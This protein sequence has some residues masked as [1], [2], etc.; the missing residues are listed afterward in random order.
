M[1]LNFNGADIRSVAKTI[2]GD[3]LEM[4]FVVDPRF[5]GN[6]ALSSTGPIR[7]KDVLP[8]LESALRMSDVAI[9]HQENLI[10]VVPVAD[11]A[12]S[13]TVNIGTA[14]P[15]FGVSVMLL[16]YAAAGTIARTA[17]NFLPRRARSGSIREE[18]LS[19]FRAQ[20]PSA[21]PFPMWSRPLMSNGCA[22]SR[23]VSI[24][25]SRPHPRQ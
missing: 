21:K 20:R 3:T 12:S 1:E 9:V 7:R 11:A 15:G 18:I 6:V 22:I 5:Q 2:L 17:E 25:S 14:E 8:V 19:L 23:L 10:K 24:R 16:R 13:G 4:N